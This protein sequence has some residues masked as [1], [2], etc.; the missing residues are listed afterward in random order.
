MS[1][2]LA[3][4][5]LETIDKATPDAL[6]AEGFTDID[7]DTLSAVLDR[8]SLRIKEAKL[9]SHVIR[10]SEAECLRQG[11][12]VTPDNKR[13]VFLHKVKYIDRVP[14]FHY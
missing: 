3:A 5:C 11:L 7:V 6:S 1:F 14:Y 13:L 10:W 4:M 8:D 9:F 2:Q 12:P